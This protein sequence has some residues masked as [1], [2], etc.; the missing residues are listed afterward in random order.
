MIAVLPPDKTKIFKLK[1]ILKAMISWTNEA[2]ERSDWKKYHHWERN[3]RTIGFITIVLQVNWLKYKKTCA[4][5]A[6]EIKGTTTQI[7]PYGTFPFLG[8]MHM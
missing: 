1:G 4:A 6:N 2:P 3:N 7:R 8:L 5:A